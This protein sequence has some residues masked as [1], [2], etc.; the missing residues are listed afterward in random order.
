MPMLD[1]IEIEGFKSIKHLEFHLGKVNVLIGPNGSGKSN[2]LG[3]MLLLRDTL[4]DDELV[5]NVLRSGG[6]NKILHFGAKNTER[7]RFEIDFHEM[8]E[9]YEQELLASEGDNLFARRFPIFGDEQWNS[10]RWQRQIIRQ[11][12]CYHFQ[13]TSPSSPIRKITDLHDNRYLRPNGSNLAAI[14]Y[15]LRQ[16]HSSS[17]SMIRHT[18]Q[19]AAPFFEDFQ[20]KPLA[21]NEDK[22]RLEWRHWGSDAY[23]DASS[24]SDGT[25][26]FL[27]LATLLLQPPRIRPSVIIMDEPELGLHPYAITLLASL[28]KQASTD[29]Q[30][31]LATQSP[32]LLDHFEPEDVLVADR[33]GG[34]TQLTRLDPEQLKAW[35]NEFSLGQLWEKN[36]FG[37][38]PARES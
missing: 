34:T 35:L 6:A 14:L 30:V 16:K 7:I 3:A 18:V 10:Y 20:L 36:E 31:I 25:L 17:Y 37:G 23:F 24:F 4:S 22:I 15:F 28:I 5:T 19:L 27:S 1:R 26:R 13:D 38:R 33:A 8:P 12:R 11:F 29:S 32:V 9:A 2:V 21:L